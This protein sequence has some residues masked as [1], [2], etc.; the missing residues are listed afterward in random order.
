M[1]YHAHL[2]ML[3]L[4]A[5]EHCGDKRIKPQGGG[6]IPIVSDV[7]DVV[8]DIGGGII[9]VGGD[10]IEGVGDLGQG[11]IDVVD[12]A[13]HFI[14]DA[15]NDV[16]PGGWGTVAA[17][18][19][20]TMGMPSDFG[21]GEAAAAEAAGTAAA[22]EAATTGLA[23]GA[24]PKTLLTNIAINSGLSAAGQTLNLSDKLQSLVQSTWR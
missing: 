17:V 23:T 1:R 15:V 2:G 3:P 18:T 4:G 19:A 8:S 12:D 9:D 22:T 24:D 20:A 7:I 6:G 16:V 13:G 14:D 11:V 5:F 21:L 10:I